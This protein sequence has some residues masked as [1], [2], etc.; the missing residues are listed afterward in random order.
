MGNTSVT[1]YDKV[2]HVT[3]TI[4]PV[5]QSNL[6]FYDRAGQATA[7]GDGLGNTCCTLRRRPV[8]SNFPPPRLTRCLFCSFMR[9]EKESYKRTPNPFPA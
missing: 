2:G 8:A 9:V 3:E 4:D 1:V 6:T 7:T 5:G